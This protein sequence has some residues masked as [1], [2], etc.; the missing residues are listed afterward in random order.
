MPVCPQRNL[1]LLRCKPQDNGVQITHNLR[2]Y[3]VQYPPFLI[4]PDGRKVLSNVYTG[5]RHRRTLD[6]EKARLGTPFVKLVV[7]VLFVDGTNLDKLSRVTARPV[8]VSLLN[9]THEVLQSDASKKLVGFFPGVHYSSEQWEDEAF[10]T[11]IREMNF[12]V[13]KQLVDQFKSLYDYGGETFTDSAGV[14][15]KLVPVVAFTATDTKE[16]RA[17][18]GVVEAA[19]QNMP[20]NTCT[21]VYADCDTFT[22]PDDLNYRL[23]DPTVELVDSTVHFDE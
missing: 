11:A 9:F 5:A 7:V 14:L 4:S 20:C 18:K 13:I 19:N 1:A 6:R 21:V 3:Y 22:D 10:K 8:V 15:W 2:N 23:A 17:L 16:A 12:Y